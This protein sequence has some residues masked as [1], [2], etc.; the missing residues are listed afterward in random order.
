[1]TAETD[2]V[3]YMPDIAGLLS[4]T[5][6]RPPGGAETQVFLLGRTLAR[7]GWKIRLVGY[8]IPGADIPAVVDGMT[9]ALRKPFVGGRL[10]S[11]L[12]EPLSVW[13]AVRRARADVVVTRAAGPHVGLVALAAKASR[14][15]FVYSSASFLDFTYQ[16]RAS[17][18]RDK[19]LF[20]IGVRLANEVVLQ[21]HEQLALYREKIGGHAVVIKS[22]T[23]PSERC[24]LTREAFLWIGRTHNVKQPMAY[25]DL[26]AAVPEA[27]FWMVLV[28][29]RAADSLDQAVKERA[30]LLPNVR[31]LA[32][33]SRS[34]VGILIARAV[35][36]VSTSVVEGMPNT[37]L[38]GWTRGVPALALNHDPDGVIRRHALGHCADGSHVAL[39]KFTRAL[40]AENDAA[41]E[42][43]CRRYIEVHHH[44]D[45]VAEQWERVLGLRAPEFA[46]TRIAGESLEVR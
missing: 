17:T 4:R 18:A 16:E 33:R 41:L 31:I 2:V 14:S 40:W 21:T 42:D 29:G 45:V 30:A 37:F 27:T 23:E 32:S 39:A 22:V 36:I 43:R 19:L 15:R 44:A 26:A 5:P 8:D 6:V 25:L 20:R 34:E 10:T 46:R 11:R 24:D 38:E 9:I 12:R 35:A 7:R 3:F 13:S 1:M 28:E